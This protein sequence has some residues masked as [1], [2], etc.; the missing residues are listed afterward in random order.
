MAIHAANIVL[1]C[2]VFW[3]RVENIVRCNLVP[4]SM[5]KMD[6]EGCVSNLM[7]PLSVG[8]AFNCYADF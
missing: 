7:A 5:L 4:E 8:D 3:Y 1:S 6:A 2:V